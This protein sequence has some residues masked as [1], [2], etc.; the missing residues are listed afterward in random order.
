MRDAGL[1]LRRDAAGNLFGRLPGAQPRSVVRP[2]RLAPGLDA[3]SGPARRRLRR[4]RRAGGGRD[5]RA[6]GPAAAPRRG[7][8]DGRAR[9]RAS[10]PAASGPAHARRRALPP[11]TPGACTIATASRWRRR[12]RPSASIAERLPEAALPEDYAALFVELHIEQ[13][14]VLEGLGRR[15]GI[16]EAIA[17]PHDLRLTFHRRGPARRHDADG[18]PPRRAAGGGRDGHGRRAG[19]AETDSPRTVATVGSLQVRPG[20]NN[21]IPGE[22]RARGR[23]PRHRRPAPPGG[24]R[25]APGHRR[26][27]P[28]GGAG[29]RSTS[30]PSPRTSP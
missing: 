28:P 27:P 4:A 26:A 24:G 6:R 14:A 10:R 5:A 30:P 25:R 3:R 19:R 16:V 7:A 12:W 21:V 15:V 11:T 9:S 2:D 29:S 23:R 17:A 20:A 22:V 13:G 18:R 1:E 8:G